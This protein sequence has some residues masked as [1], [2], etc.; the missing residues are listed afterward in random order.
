M[1]DKAGNWLA[2]VS[3]YRQWRLALADEV[4]AAS[5]RPDEALAWITAVWST[6]TYEAIDLESF[7][8]SP[9]GCFVSVLRLKK[10]AAHEGVAQFPARMYTPEDQTE[11]YHETPAD[12]QDCDGKQPGEP[13][14]TTK[15]PEAEGQGPGEEVAGQKVP[16]PPHHP[17]P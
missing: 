11:L 7:K 3:A 6:T 14:G 12:D 13:T 16:L 1:G 17:G 5:A 10:N 15:M 9:N 2:S 8:G 4:L